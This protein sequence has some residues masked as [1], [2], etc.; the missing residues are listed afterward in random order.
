MADED[1]SE[2]INVPNLLQA[3]VTIGGPGAVSPEVLEQAELMIANMTGNYLEWVRRDLVALRLAFEN[4]KTGTGNARE[5][6]DD[7]FRIVH[8]MRG[9]GGSFGYKLITVIGNQLCHLIGGLDDADP[10]EI[11]AIGLHIEAMHLVIA[12]NIRDDGGPEA[13][14]MLKGL[15]KVGARLAV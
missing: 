3:K 14:R 7:I 6:L 1:R 8:D 2:L 9:Q 15:K 4:L 12:R 11:E 13:E 5:K 10:P